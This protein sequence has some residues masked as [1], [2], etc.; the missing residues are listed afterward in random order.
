MTLDKLKTQKEG[1]ILSVGGD[2]ELRCRL[3]DMGLIPK[4]KVKVVKL[5]PLGDPIQLNLRGYDLT[6]RKEDAKYIEIE[7]IKGDNVWFL[8]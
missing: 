2:K 1:I 3:I 6:I 7:E 4:T 5:A 8:P